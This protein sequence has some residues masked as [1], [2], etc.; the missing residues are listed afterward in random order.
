MRAG[1]NVYVIVYQL[2]GATAYA[3][4]GS[5]SAQ[6]AQALFERT[7]P[8]GAVFVSIRE[9]DTRQER[10]DFLDWLEGRR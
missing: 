3:E 8:A 5:D 1:K 10:A 2:A 4:I 9:R 6:Q 7:K